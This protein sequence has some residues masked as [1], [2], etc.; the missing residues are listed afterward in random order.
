MAGDGPVVVI[1]GTGMLGGQVVTALLS[2]GKRVRALVRPKSD[3]AR[4]ARSY[5]GFELR[6]HV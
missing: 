2:R 3:A 5:G 6:F 1:G 4:L